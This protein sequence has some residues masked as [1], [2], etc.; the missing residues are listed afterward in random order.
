MLDN[1]LGTRALALTYQRPRLRVTTIH[2]DEKIEQATSTCASSL[3]FVYAGSTAFVC[4]PRM[5]SV[6]Q[7][8]FTYHRNYL[9]SG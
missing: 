2:Y 6:E 7:P 1:L 9:Y 4:F 8:Y 3:V 5:P